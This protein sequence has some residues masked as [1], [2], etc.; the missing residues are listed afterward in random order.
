MTSV[1]VIISTANPRMDIFQ[2]VLDCVDEQ[3]LPHSQYEVIIVDNNSNPPL[4]LE[5]LRKD[6]EMTLRL[7]REPKQGLSYARIAGIREATG[8]LFIFVDDDNFLDSKYLEQALKIHQENPEIGAYGGI[9]EGVLERPVGKWK[10]KLL[11][12]LGV[13]NYGNEII[14][15]TNDHWGHWEPIGA[16]MVT[17]RDVAEKFV[18]LIEQVPHAG[19]LGRSGT[20]LLSGEDSLFARIANRLGYACSY[21]PSLKLQHF[22]KKGRLK[23]GYFA[24]LIKGHGHSYVVL[25]RVLGGPVEQFGWPICIARLGYRLKTAGLTGAM[26]WFWDIGYMKEAKNKPRDLKIEPFFTTG[27]AAAK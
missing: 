27:A 17:R 24:R 14:T 2:R 26:M 23:L 20:A 4:A 10:T 13:R 19:N 12:Y 16:G 1:S 7:V 3:S 21:Q 25:Q 22:I 9:S 5:D 11:P 18:E 6:R 15:S 8:E